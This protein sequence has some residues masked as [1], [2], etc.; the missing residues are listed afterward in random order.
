VFD[1]RTKCAEIVD[2]KSEVLGLV[3]AALTSKVSS[4]YNPDT[5]RCYAEVV[6]TKNFSYTYKEH[7]VPDN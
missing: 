6:T 1:L 5:N 4:H 3:G 2:K 7:P